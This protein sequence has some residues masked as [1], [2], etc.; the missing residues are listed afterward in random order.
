MRGFQNGLVFQ[1]LASGSPEIL[2]FG[3]SK[4]GFLRQDLGGTYMCRVAT[5]RGIFDGFLA[6]F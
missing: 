1:I 4:N 5:K 6:V 3:A 2:R